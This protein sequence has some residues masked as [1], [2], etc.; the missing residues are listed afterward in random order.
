MMIGSEDK[1]GE[2]HIRK[3]KAKA[4]GGNK[5]RRITGTAE[6]SRPLPT[7]TTSRDE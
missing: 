1:G 6:G 7:A 4:N 3:K 5:S 2:R